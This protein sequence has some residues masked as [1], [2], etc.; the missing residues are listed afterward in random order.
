M[1]SYDTTVMDNWD[2]RLNYGV[3]AIG[4]I[5]TRTGNRADGEKLGDSRCTT[6]RPS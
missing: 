4:N 3:S 1:L 2:L 6:P 5:L